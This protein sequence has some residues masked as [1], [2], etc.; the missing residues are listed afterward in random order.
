MVQVLL[1]GAQPSPGFLKPV[2]AP[3]SEDAFA[4]EP[5]DGG[6]GGVE[7]E[8]ARRRRG[9]ML[10]EI[11]VG[12]RGTLAGTAELHRPG[13][14]GDGRGGYGLT[15]RVRRMTNGRLSR[16]WVQRLRING[17]ATN[18][19]LGSFPVVGLATARERALDNRRKIEQ[20]IDPRIAENPTPTVADALEAV[21]EGRSGSWK[22]GGRSAEIWRNSVR[23]HAD[24]LIHRPVDQIDTG[25]VLRF[26]GPLWTD[27]HDTAKKVRQRLSL[28]FRWAM[29]AGHRPDD[30]AGEAL[31]AALPR[32]GAARRHM[33]ALP[34]GEVP[35]ALAAIDNSAAYPTT[36][37]AMRM[38]ALTAT[39]SGEA[40]GMCWDEIE[41]D[42][43]T[44]PGERTKVGREFRVPLSPEALA[45]LDEARR[46]SDGTPDSLVFPSARGRQITPDA[47]SK[48][49]P[50]RI[51]GI[52]GCWHRL[53]L[54]C[55]EDAAGFEVG[56]VGEAVGAASQDLE[57]VVGAYL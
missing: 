38:L 49:G 37:L 27:R 50:A 46:H 54:L 40:R 6:V 31:L 11:A 21:I 34:P 28:A 4:S 1:V 25:D 14:Y 5:F 33:A 56:G 20:G 57:E 51:R 15:L 45:V 24:N 53:G 52:E 30:P 8:V 32:N 48:L 43:W 29:A 2:V 41:G 55:H 9:H 42:T 44:I 39:R 47:L 26:I 10:N 19:G 35:A 17:R 3:N 23:N 22:N 16:V 18:L 7:L 13:V 12:P 36:K